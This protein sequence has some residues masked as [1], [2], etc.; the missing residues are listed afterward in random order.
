[1]I[2]APDFAEPLQAWRVW[3]VVRKDDRFTLGSIV[4]RTLWPPGEALSAECLRCRGLTARILRRRRHG[5]PEQDC[6]CGI[7]AAELDAVGEYLSEAAYRGVARVLGQ[8][9]LWGTVIECERGL[10]ASRA[11]PVRIYVPADA[12]HP[13]RVDWDEIALGLWHY[14][15]P[16]EP[17]TSLHEPLR[18]V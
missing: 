12:G 4:Q 5:A 9:A 17:V 6:E 10:R 2:E 13:W 8:V 1:V 18:G 11:Y 14:G 15:V 3:R 16:I 7:Y